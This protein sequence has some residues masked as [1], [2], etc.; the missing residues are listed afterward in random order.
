MSN[1]G[2]YPPWIDEAEGKQCDKDLTSRTVK[3]ERY[4]KIWQDIDDLTDGIKIEL[5]KICPQPCYA[6]KSRLS[7]KLHISHFKGKA[8]LK[9]MNA[10]EVPIFKAVYSFDITTLAV[11]LGS[12]LG[13]WLG[14]YSYKM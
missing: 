13:L 8:L 2:C 5:M 7:E 9:I 6:I 1:F 10:E 3:Q 14:R 4:K 12:Q 11:E